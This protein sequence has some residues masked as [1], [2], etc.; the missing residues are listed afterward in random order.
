MKKL[1]I[2]KK[3]IESL[4]EELKKLT[5]ELF[6]L[7]SISLAG[8]DNAKKKAKINTVKKNIARIKTRL[9]NN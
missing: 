5:K 6:R 1:E 8:E 4:P 7:K 3:K 2:M 9:N